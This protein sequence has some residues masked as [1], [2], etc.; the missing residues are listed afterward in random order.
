MLQEVAFLDPRFKHLNFLSSDEKT[1]TIERVKIKMLFAIAA[2]CDSLSCKDRKSVKWSLTSRL[3]HS[4][5][6]KEKGRCT[7][8]IV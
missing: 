6:G 5:L 4:H 3:N 7:Y 8:Y 1:D 2:S